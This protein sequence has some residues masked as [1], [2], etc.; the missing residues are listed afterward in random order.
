MASSFLKPFEYKGKFK[1]SFNNAL[2]FTGNII[3]SSNENIA[4]KNLFIPVTKNHPAF[5]LKISGTS[6]FGNRESD[7]LLI[8]FKTEEERENI[9]ECD[10]TNEVFYI[11]F[12]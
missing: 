10:F 6:L 9:A 8:N 1:M 4:G 2:I 5:T 3:N 7:S 12:Q 11:E